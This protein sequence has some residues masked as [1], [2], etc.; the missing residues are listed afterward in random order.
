[1]NAFCLLTYPVLILLYLFLSQST[2]FDMEGS[3]VTLRP[4]AWK[5]CYLQMVCFVDFSV[6][7][8]I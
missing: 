1:M 6:H 5:T 8:S 4:A 7:S 3:P 2:G